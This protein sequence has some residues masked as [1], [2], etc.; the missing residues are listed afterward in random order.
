MWIDVEK[1]VAQPGKCGDFLV[2]V[3]STRCLLGYDQIKI[4][5]GKKEERV[6]LQRVDL[7]SKLLGGGNNTRM[8]YLGGGFDCHNSISLWN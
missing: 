2:P 7:K 8:E 4:T 5:N 6:I 3:L 1:Q